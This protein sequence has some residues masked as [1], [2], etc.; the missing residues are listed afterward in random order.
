MLHLVPLFV[1]VM[2]IAN[3]KLYSLSTKGLTFQMFSSDPTVH[4]V[5]TVAISPVIRR[6]DRWAAAHPM[7]R[8]HYYCSLPHLAIAISKSFIVCLRHSHWSYPMAPSDWLVRS[9]IKI[10]LPR[11]LLCHSQSLS[12]ATEVLEQL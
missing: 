9:D 5:H 2:M 8:N 3:T 1:D 4:L 7:T 12:A 11:N 6:T 10:Q